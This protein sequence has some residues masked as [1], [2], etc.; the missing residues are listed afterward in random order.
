MSIS[1]IFIQWTLKQKMKL[2]PVQLT[3]L[4]NRAQMLCLLVGC[5][6]ASIRVTARQLRH[7]I[8]LATENLTIKGRVQQPINRTEQRKL[9]VPNTQLLQVML[10]E[11]KIVHSILQPRRIK[12]MEAKSR[13]QVEKILHQILKLVPMKMG[14]SP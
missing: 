10:L 7:P 11:T 12:E 5:E 1:N 13:P 14:L 3:V 9:I 6:A 2:L 8:T 4:Q